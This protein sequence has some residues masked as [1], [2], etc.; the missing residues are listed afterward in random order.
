MAFVILNNGNFFRLAKTEA[1]LNDINIPEQF[2]TVVNISD[3]DFN[4]YVTNIKEPIVSDGNVSFQAYP[5]TG[6]IKHENESQLKTHFEMFKN[7]A[8]LF[9]KN[10]SERQLAVQCQNYLNYLNTVDMSSLSYP[11]N[12]E[13]HCHDNSIVFLHKDQIG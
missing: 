3:D 13:K 9:I 5:T 4:S 2:K 6:I 8:N 10:N 11:I 7:L 12:W 1:D